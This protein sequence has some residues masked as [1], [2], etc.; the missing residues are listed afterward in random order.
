MRQT[1][2]YVT[3]SIPTLEGVLVVPV[4]VLPTFTP[5]RS[6]GGVTGGSGILSD[7]PLLLLGTRFLAGGD[8]V[9]G[10]GRSF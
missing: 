2:T 10:K 7:F 1:I 8:G 6:F 5:M 4:L 3:A 9:G